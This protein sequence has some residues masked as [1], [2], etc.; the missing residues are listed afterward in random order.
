M[1]SATSSSVLSCKILFVWYIISFH[2]EGCIHAVRVSLRHSLVHIFLCRFLHCI[3]IV[4]I[5][6]L[7]LSYWVSQK[8]RNGL[9]LYI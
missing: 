8:C 4:C 3:S 2:F 7:V 5:G 1:A 9:Q 6:V